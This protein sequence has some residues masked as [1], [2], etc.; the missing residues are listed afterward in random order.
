M[1]IDSI[2]I[3]ATI[4]K[5]QLIVREDK[6]LSA[7][8]KSMFE[9]LILIITL[10]ANR[11]NLNS[12]NSSKPPST[13]PNWIKRSREKTGKKPGG[14][15]GHVG[16]T[17][18]KVDNPDRV[19]QIK[20]DRRK[21]P[22]GQ[23]RQVGFEARQ[24]FDIDISRVVI[25]Y[26]AQIL[27]DD[28]G[29]RFVAPFPEGVSKAVQYGAGIKAHSV[30]MSQFQ[31]VPY[32]RIQDHFADQFRIPVSEGSIFNFNKE[33]YQLLGDFENRTKN[34]LAASELA[35]A[36]ET[37]IN[38]GGKGHWLHCLSNSLWT[39]Y[40][41]HEKR[42][43]DAINDIGVLP[44]FK[45]ILCHDH[46]KPYYKYDCTHALCNAHHIRELTRAWEQDGQKWA[47]EM[48]Q[49]LETINRTVTN[50]DGALDPDESQ[51]YREQYRDLIKKAQIEC[52][53]PIGSK[54]KG[55]RGRIK[56]TKSRNLLER[57]RDY[58]N[59][60]LRFMDVAYVPFTNNLGENDI[61]MTKV[62]QKISGC[63]RSIE[64]AQVFCRVRSYL[65]TCRK[66]GVSASQA[67]S[68]LFAGKLPDF[69]LQK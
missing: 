6:Q 52:P 44:G 23:Y 43:T 50:N 22:A 48:K 53:E 65:S 26:R 46:W 19:E 28:C 66:Q 38:L 24:V 4:K 67:L 15:N 36:D 37:G 42:G 31:L 56:K 27:E 35:H 69:L 14:Q 3:Q 7:A 39:L 21:L 5:A 45:G 54:E 47:L 1:K 68:L 13:D 9:I 33:A 41:P 30:Y 63:F 59:D 58:E 18:Q 40:C 16:T 49:L 25:E 29:Q 17:L 64:G 62:Q 11:L 51:K 55:K 20:V 61:R 34:E 57:L 2:D 10:L 12:T 32:N 8:T 60:T